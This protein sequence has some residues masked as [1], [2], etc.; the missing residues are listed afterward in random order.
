MK[1]YRL[2]DPFLHAGGAEYDAV[3]VEHPEHGDQAGNG[4][5]LHQHAE[6]VLGAHHAGVEQRQ[7]RNGHQQHQSGRDNHPG[8]ITGVERGWGGHGRG[9]QGH[10]GNSNGT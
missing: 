7:A 9:G 3:A 10:Q 6:H 5:A 1:L 8:G 4:E 2:I